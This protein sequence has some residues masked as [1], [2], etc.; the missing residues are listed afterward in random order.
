MALQTVLK[1]QVKGQSSITPSVPS[2]T[3]QSYAT[4]HA[5]WLRVHRLDVPHCVARPC[6]CVLLLPRHNGLAPAAHSALVVKHLAPARVRGERCGMLFVA[7]PSRHEC[8]RTDNQG[9]NVYDGS[10]LP[11]L[12][13]VEE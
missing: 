9:E 3:E 2:P 1:R 7:L 13:E 5:Q 12:T 4:H 11:C 8:E 10:I 6:R